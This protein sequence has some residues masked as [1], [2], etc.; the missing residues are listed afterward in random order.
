MS[1]PA[2]EEIPPAL[3]DSAN[4]LPGAPEE[5]YR[6]L[7][8]LSRVLRRAPADF[9]PGLVW[10]DAENRITSVTLQSEPITI[11]R[12]PSCDVVLGGPRVSRRHCRLR[13]ACG[14]GGLEIE[15]LASSNGTFV[16]TRRLSP[17]WHPLCSGDVV[18]VGGHALACLE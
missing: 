10:L 8:F 18:R 4:G 14:G 16:N 3:F 15:D 5:V 12:D 17:G 13:L 1:L 7:Q 2:V 6:R 9:G 11:G